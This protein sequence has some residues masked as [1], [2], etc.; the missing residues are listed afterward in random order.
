MYED[1][2]GKTALVSGAGKRSGIGYAISRKLAS[3]GMNIIIA[4]LG[5]IPAEEQPIKTGTENEMA[6]IADELSKTWGID[7]MAVNV[8]VSSS[9]SIRGMLDEVETRH[10]HIDV[11]CNNAGASFG[12]P[13][14]VHTYD[15]GAWMKTIDVNLHGVFRMTQAV[16]PM[17]MGEP[18]TIIN[19]ASRAGK[20]P[21]LFNGAYA[22][23][24]A[25][26][27]MLT[28]VMA[29]ELAGLKIRVNAICP[30]QVETDL[31][32]WRFGL[33]AQFFNTTIEDRR[34]KMCE[35]IPVGRIGSPAEVAR[36][37]AF[38]AS[39]QSSYMTGQ[40]INITG[41]QLMEL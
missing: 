36:L 11:L 34:Q 40:A 12:V 1:L 21:P 31:E 26:V 5:D 24:K 38:L 2:K 7:A 3:C 13:N 25:G 4:D 22:V 18:G 10:D 35:E 29:K 37:V 19:T 27:I 15:E 14:A 41:G 33:E 16:M 17:M 39:N 23:A 8:D 6:D 9:E 28:K 32:N 30:G 20:V